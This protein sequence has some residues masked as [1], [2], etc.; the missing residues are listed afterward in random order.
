M[1]RIEKRLEKF[2][3]PASKQ[4]I[5]REDLDSI[6]NHFFPDQWSFGD[7]RGSH[8][9]RVFHPKF[10]EFP[11]DYGQEGM[12]LIPTKH[13]QKI[14]HQYLKDLCKA[15]ERIKEFQSDEKS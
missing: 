4:D 15:I 7:T 14:R 5:P 3:N 11:E 12:L 6:L 13:G 1:S 10:K 2:C 9:Y 8:N